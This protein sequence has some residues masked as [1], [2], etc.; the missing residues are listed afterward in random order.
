MYPENVPQIC[1]E[2][3][4]VILAHL[5]IPSQPVLS[6]LLFLEVFLCP[7]QSQ[8]NQS[9]WLLLFLLLTHLSTSVTG[10]VLAKTKLSLL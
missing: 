7:F 10:I 3:D 8:L 6:L 1:P 2:V 4:L 9:V 5:L